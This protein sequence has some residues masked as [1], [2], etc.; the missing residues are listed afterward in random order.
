MHMQCFSKRLYSV[1]PRVLHPPCRRRWKGEPSDDQSRERMASSPRTA[2][3][4]GAESDQHINICSFAVHCDRIWPS[5]QWHMVYTGSGN[6]PYVQFESVDDFIPEPK[7]SKFAMG[8]QT[9]RR[10]M[11]GTRG[12]AEL[13]S[14]GPRVMRAPLCAK[15]SNVCS[16]FEPGGSVVV[17]W[18]DRSLGESASPFIDEGDGLTSERERVY[19]Y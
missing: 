18:I 16:R 17:Y 5:T 4:V 10:K 12:P 15:C 11:G 8:L 14:E 2:P 19:I 13:W 7:C 9:R 6:V 3:T 1:T